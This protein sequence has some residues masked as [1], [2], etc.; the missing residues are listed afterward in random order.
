MYLHGISMKI[1]LGLL[2]K[3]VEKFKKVCFT[4]TS[5]VCEGEKWNKKCVKWN[6]KYYLDNF[7]LYFSHLR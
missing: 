5:S 2:D 3:T 4:S 1:F 7:S 6:F